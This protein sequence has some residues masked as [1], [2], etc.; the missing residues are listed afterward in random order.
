M[1]NIKAN[2]KNIR[3]TQRRTS[4]NRHEVRTYRNKVKQ[5]RQQPNDASLRSAFKQ[6]DSAVAKGKMHKNKGNR[7]KSRLANTYAKSHNEKAA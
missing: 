1:A 5:A 4:R 7:L 3:K 6:I 2:I